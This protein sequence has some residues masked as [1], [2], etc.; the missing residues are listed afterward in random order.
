[1]LANSNLVGCRRLKPEGGREDLAHQV[2]TDHTTSNSGGHSSIPAGA[3]YLALDQAEGTGSHERAAVG[4]DHVLAGTVER[5]QDANGAE[6]A[7]ARQAFQNRLPGE[8]EEEQSLRLELGWTL[9]PIDEGL[10]IV[11]VG[12]REQLVEMTFPLREPS[13]IA[14]RLEAIGPDRLSAA[15]FVSTK[16]ERDCIRVGS[17]VDGELGGMRWRSEQLS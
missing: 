13:E 9:K 15:A 1:M 5:A 14:V 6:D 17:D 12:E 16:P 3:T 2:D 7:S 4:T 8:L 10:T 11:Q